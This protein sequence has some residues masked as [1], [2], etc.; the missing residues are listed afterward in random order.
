MEVFDRLGARPWARQAREELR[1]AR[2]STAVREESGVD[3]LSPQQLRI[4]QHVADGATNREVA[5]RLFLSTRTVDHPLRNIYS[6]LGIRSR[7]EL[8]RLVDS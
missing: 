7:V 5:A 6:K 4:A 3:R 2:G 8:S 1:A